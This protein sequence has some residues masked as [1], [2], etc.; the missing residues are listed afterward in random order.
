M[1]ALEGESNAGCLVWLTPF[2]EFTSIGEFLY[3]PVFLF[4]QQNK[5]NNSSYPVRGIL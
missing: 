3:D 1:G 2:W 5:V 4:L